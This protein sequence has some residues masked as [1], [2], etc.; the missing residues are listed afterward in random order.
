MVTRTDEELGAW[1]ALAMLP[2]GAVAYCAS[3]Y[4]LGRRLLGPARERILAFLAGLGILQ[5]AS[6]VPFLD[7][8]VFIAQARNGRHVASIRQVVGADGRQVITNELYA[9]GPDGRA[10]PSSPLPHD[11]ADDL[12]ANGYDLRWH[13]QAA[14]WWR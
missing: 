1:L 12:A 14:G 11:L 10:V 4:A 13:E 8:V 7:L 2:L 3:A 9:P 6:L 5:A